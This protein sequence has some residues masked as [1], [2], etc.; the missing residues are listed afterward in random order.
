VSAAQPVAPVSPGVEASLAVSPAE[1]APPPAESPT[2]DVRPVV[3]DVRNLVTYFYTYD[4][5]VRA[6]EGVSFKLRRGETLGLVGETGCGK[7]VTSFSITRLIPD[8]P[9]R[10]VSGKVLFREP[11]SCGG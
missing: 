4:G 9:G 3:L 8:P 6:L 5:V 10:V 2:T 1:P 7:S 11:T